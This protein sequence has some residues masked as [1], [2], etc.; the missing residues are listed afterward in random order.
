M[1]L[2]YVEKLKS[3]NVGI[4]TSKTVELR[5]IYGHCCAGPHVALLDTDLTELNV[6]RIKL[7]EEDMLTQVLVLLLRIKKMKISLYLI[8]TTDGII[9]SRQL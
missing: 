6:L 9:T 8:A 4:N 7:D 5:A 1:V 2:C 3:N